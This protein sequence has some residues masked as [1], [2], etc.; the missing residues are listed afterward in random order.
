MKTDGRKLAQEGRM[1]CS[2]NERSRNKGRKEK[3]MAKEKE[4]KMKN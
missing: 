3:L 4:G 2:K 1:N